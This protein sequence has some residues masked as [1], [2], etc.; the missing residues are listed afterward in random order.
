MKKKV[1]AV[2]LATVLL[3]SLGL[4]MAAPV[5]AN[6]PV[7]INVQGTACPFFAG[8]TLSWL[9]TNYPPTTPP[10]SCANFHNDTSDAAMMPPSI[11][12]CGGGTLDITATGDW[13]WGPSRF[14]GPDG[15]STCG[16]PIT[17][18]SHEEYDDLGISLVEGYPGNLVGV[19]L[20]DDP[21]STTAP[22]IL[23]Q[24]DGEGVMKTPLLQQTFIIGSSLADIQIPA[25]A[26]R[27]FFGFFDGSEWNTNRG[28]VD[29]T[30]TMTCPVSELV[31]NLC[32]AQDMEVG[33]VTVDDDGTNLTVTYEIDVPGWLIT[34]TH[35][36]VVTD[37]DDFPVANSKKHNNPK[38]GHFTWSEDH[39]PPVD[40]YTQ[41]VPLADIGDGVTA[42]DL[43]C[44]AAHA[45]VIHVLGEG[46][47]NPFWA[48]G[49]QNYLPGPE[50]YGGDIPYGVTYYSTDS[51]MI[52]PPDVVYLGP[53]M[54]QWDGFQSLGFGGS[55]EITFDKPIFNGPGEYDISVHEITGRDVAG[56][57]GYPEE[58]AE[59]FIWVDGDWVSIGTVSSLDDYDDNGDADGIGTVSIPD[60]YMYVEKIK[61]VDTSDINNFSF[62][63]DGYDIDAVDACFLYDGDETAWGGACDEEN[64]YIPGINDDGFVHFFNLDGKGNW[65]SYFEYIIQ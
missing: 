27:L 15:C 29:V 38:P 36:E 9:Q 31:T 22:A 30:V 34:E 61:I 35:L 18:S 54:P 19:F 47:E 41:V 21:P 10:G 45:V 57:E 8:Q 55:V 56:R 12:V 23:K 11:D 49:Q 40:T 50:R 1:L 37:P 13:G 48:T 3:L 53:P 17:F 44:I 60:E 63:S 14:L 5:S 64:Y 26:T 7:V 28:S 59:V 16:Y 20:G 2:M 6:G 25:G 65:A 32:A 43:V 46:C 58:T 51:K 24:S 39:N 42:G 62:A 4:V 33:W 52:G